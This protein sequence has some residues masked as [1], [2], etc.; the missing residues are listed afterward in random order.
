MSCRTEDEAVANA[1][2]CGLDEYRLVKS[3]YGFEDA[4]ATLPPLA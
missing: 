4:A 2:I 1:S 3:V